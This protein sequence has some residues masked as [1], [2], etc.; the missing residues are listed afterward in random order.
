MSSEIAVEESGN[1]KRIAQASL[2]M[3]MQNGRLQDVFI[4]AMIPNTM[5]PGKP[6]PLDVSWNL[7]SGDTWVA[8][9][10]QVTQEVLSKY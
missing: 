6:Y 2:R 10:L 3:L 5:D 8:Q 4:M 9:T 7:F 1:T